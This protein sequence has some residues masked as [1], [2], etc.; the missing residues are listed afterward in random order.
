MTG[1]DGRFSIQLPP[2]TYMVVTLTSG[3]LPAPA[4]VQATVVAGQ[5]TTVELLLDSGI[6]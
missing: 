3:I 2:G 4:S 1:A 6:R 5:M